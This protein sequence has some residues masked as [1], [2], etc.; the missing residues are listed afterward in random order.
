MQEQGGGQQ[1]V[2]QGDYVDYQDYADYPEYPDEG[3]TVVAT[4][5]VAAVPV[6]APGVIPLPSLPPRQGGQGFAQ[7]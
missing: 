4:P 2:Q 1:G 3:A 5:V 7:Y 6:V